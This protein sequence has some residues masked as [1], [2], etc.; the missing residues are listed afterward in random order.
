VFSHCLWTSHEFFHFCRK[1][2]ELPH[3]CQAR[4]WHHYHQDLR[5]RLRFVRVVFDL[6]E[7]FNCGCVTAETVAGA[8][9]VTIFGSHWSRV[10]RHFL[11]QVSVRRIRGTARFVFLPPLLQIENRVIR[12]DRLRRKN[13][14]LAR[15]SQRYIRRLI[16]T[17]VQELVDD[18]VHGSRCSSGSLLPHYVLLLD[19]LIQEGKPLIWQL[20]V[21]IIRAADILKIYVQSLLQVLCWWNWD[22][23]FGIGLLGGMLL[24]TCEVGAK[25]V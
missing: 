25:F 2:S 23:P 18:W 1:A 13:L 20:L 11:Q 4:L 7:T 14:H 22:R 12:L 8:G 10:V 19:T 6:R 16:V 24:S 5:G 17:T 3:T 9:A 21:T 15:I